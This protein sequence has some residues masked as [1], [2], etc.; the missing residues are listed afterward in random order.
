MPMYA[1]LLYRFVCRHTSR[2]LAFSRTNTQTPKYTHTSTTSSSSELIY[3]LCAVV[4][5]GLFIIRFLFIY[6][7][8]FTV[9]LPLEKFKKIYGSLQHI[10]Q[11]HREKAYKLLDFLV[12]ILV[13]YVQISCSTVCFSSSRSLGF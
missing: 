4:F 5:L 9:R 7:F 2:P 6:L 10:I 3:S 1:V 12:I 11:N 8:S 13:Q